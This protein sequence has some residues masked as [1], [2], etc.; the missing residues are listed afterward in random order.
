MRENEP[1]EIPHEWLCLHREVPKNLVAA[2]V[3]NKLDYV[4]VYS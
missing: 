3:A 4:A 1:R 2:P